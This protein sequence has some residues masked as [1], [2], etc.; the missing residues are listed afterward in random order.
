MSEQIKNIKICI[1]GGGSHT[2]IASILRDIA[3]T[4]SIHGITL[5]LM[6]IDEHRL[7]RSYMLARKY[8]DELK[9]PINLERT[10]DTKACIE[11]AS[12]VINLAFAIGYDHWGIQVEAAERHGY[13]RGIDA[14]EWNMVCCY[15]SLTGFKQYNV[16][17]KIAGIM[18][19]IN[20]DAWLIQVS[21]PVLETTT[22]VHRQYPKLKIIGYCHGAPGGVRLLV[23][24]AL[25]L[26]MRRIEWQAVGLNHVVFLTRFKYNG[27][28]AYHLIDE[29]IEK[30]AEEFWASYVPG[31]WE[32]TLSRAAVDMY[33]LY[34]LYP[35]GDT[36]R[37]GTWKYHRDLKT[38]IYWYGPIGGVD[39]EV[40]WGIRMLRNQEAEAKL[41][42]AA[43]NPSIKATEAYPPV[44]SGEQIIDFIDSVV[45]NVERRMILN[46]PNNGVLPRLPS[47]AI[48]EAPVYVKGEVIRPEAIENVPNKMYSYVWYPRIA[49]T[50]RALEA[51]L[52]GSKELLIEAL[53]FDPRT[54]STEQAREVIDEILNL[55]FNEDMKKHYK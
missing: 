45:N 29:W 10:T 52:A 31:P 30:K 50:E 35:L 1:I 41:E 12:F 55:P 2:F 24:K 34:G 43:F 13:Y 40:G 32:E 27:E 36:A 51:Y 48:V 15:P 39:S 17:L 23:E 8:F 33:R 38:K 25:K 3:L 21:N 28:D 53:M 42:N 9:V 18:D 11:G 5:T 54:K 4:K 22:L 16:A 6:D 46:I 44:K 37:S 47:D 14:T 7:A 19:E 20:R 26:D 49:V